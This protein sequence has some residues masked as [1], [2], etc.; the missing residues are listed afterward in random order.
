MEATFKFYVSLLLR[1]R[2]T[3][4]SGLHSVVKIEVP[5]PPPLPSPWSSVEAH[6]LR[7]HQTQKLTGNQETIFVVYP[8]DQYLCRPAVQAE[9]PDGVLVAVV[10]VPNR[11][12]VVRRRYHDDSLV[13][14]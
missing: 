1:C 11:Y 12:S 9:A 10:V 4:A 13:K 2:A 6:R 14:R 5:P 3:G 7:L 8:A